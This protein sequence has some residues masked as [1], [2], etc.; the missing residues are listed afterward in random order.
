MQNSANYSV[1]TWQKRMIRWCKLRLKLSVMSW[2]EPM[3][4]CFMLGVCT[5]WT[6]NYLF[7]W[8]SLVFFLTH[9]LMWFLFDYMLL[10]TVQNGKLPF[11]KFEYIIAW[12]YRE[13]ICFYL[14]LKAA[15]NPT[16][17]WRD[18]VYR[19]KWGGL[20][21][22]IKPTLTAK[23]K[24][25]AKDSSLKNGNNNSSTNKLL[26]SNGTSN[27][28][29]EE[30]DEETMTVSNNPSSVVLNMNQLGSNGT[31]MNSLNS[32]SNSTTIINLNG[33][34]NLINGNANN[35]LTPSKIAKAP[36]LNHKR[37][38]SF[39]AM[40]NNT[41]NNTNSQYHQQQQQQFNSGYNSNAADGSNGNNLPPYSTFDSN[42]NNFK[43]PSNHLK[44][45][46]SN[47]LNSSRSHHQYHH[48]ISNPL[49]PQ[50]QQPHYLSANANQITSDS[51]LK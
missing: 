35:Q 18:G 41:N 28:D 36:L 47:L 40:I 9:V 21:E 8:N 15:A 50:H 30:E 46:N 44:T 22:E 4:E 45:P 13:L 17:K 37:T 3:Q 14:F 23:A 12:L 38:S 10:K 49:Q 31:S 26:N 24:I 51:K 19:L 43:S 25:S 5:S 29:D 6:V 32:T 34:S 1:P 39:T 48:S 33:S 42:A 2:L 16:V 7:G 20:A 11:S 27:I